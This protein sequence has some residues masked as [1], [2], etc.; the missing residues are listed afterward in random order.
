MIKEQREKEKNENLL[1]IICSSIDESE[2]KLSENRTDWNSILKASLSN[3]FLKKIHFIAH[4][5]SFFR[6][7]LTFINSILCS[8]QQQAIAG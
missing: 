1:K 4:Q 6:V 8:K 5:K 3:K 2:F 7:F